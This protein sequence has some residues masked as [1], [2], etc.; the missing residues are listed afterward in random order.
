LNKKILHVIEVRGYGGAERLLPDLLVQ[1]AAEFPALNI[2]LAIM[3]SKTGNEVAQSMIQHIKQRSSID[4]YLLPYENKLHLLTRLFSLSNILR[5]VRPSI[6]HTHLTIAD[7]FIGILDL[8]QMCDDAQLI[9]TLH[10]FP[11]NSLNNLREDVS[12]QQVLK[13]SK[14][15]RIKKIIYSRYKKIA[16]V[17]NFVQHVYV[18]LGI[19][20]KLKSDFYII[21]NGIPAS[22]VKRQSISMIPQKPK[23]ISFG[24]LLR[25]KGLDFAIRALAILKQKGFDIE[26]DIFGEGN[27]KNDLRRLAKELDVESLIRFRGYQSNIDLILT[28][29]S[30]AVLPSLAEPFGLVYIESFRSGTPVVAF[31]LP[32]V[33][34]LIQHEKNGLLVQPYNVVA[35]ASAIERLISDEQFRHQLSEYAKIDFESRFTL[36]RVVNRYRNL[37]C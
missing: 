13:Q 10:G 31:D 24:R 18:E 11:D 5:K 1:L 15:T 16:F 2:S 20:D 35:L 30:I 12:I 23:L 8:L 28:D 27:Y 9:T 34:E 32:A 6:I 25:W 19:V 36:M 22:N 14:F 37:Y 3:V 7:F 4:I 29:D 21:H 17:S 26:L 33:N